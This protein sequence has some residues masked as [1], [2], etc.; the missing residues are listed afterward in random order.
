MKIFS[1]AV[2]ASLLLMMALVPASAF[3]APIITNGNFETGDL[4]G[5]TANPLGMV[6]LITPGQYTAADGTAIAAESGS[7]FAVLYSNP[8]SPGT[9]T[10]LSQTFNATAG[11]L[12]QDMLF[13]MPVPPA[14]RP[15]TDRLLFYRGLQLS[16]L[17][18]A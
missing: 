17:L 9:F 3:A 6:A 14:T 13:T 10:T 15:L 16:A 11:L 18:I 1:F 2:V 4:S 5:W 7:D 8:G 12:F